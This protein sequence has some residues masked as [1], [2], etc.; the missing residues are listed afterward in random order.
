MY[1]RPCKLIS[2]I[3]SA[4][5]AYRVATYARLPALYRK[6]PRRRGSRVYGTSCIINGAV[7]ACMML[8]LGSSAQAFGRSQC[9]MLRCMPIATRVLSRGHLA[10]WPHTTPTPYSSHVLL[11]RSTQR[12]DLH[13]ARTIRWN[14]CHPCVLDATGWGRVHPS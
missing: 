8:V 6:L 1:K 2:L 3:I 5:G 13:R 9:V 4:K 14:G 11:D 12:S 10:S 7:A